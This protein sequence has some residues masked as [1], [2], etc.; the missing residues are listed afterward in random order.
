MSK[1]SIPGGGGSYV[2]LNYKGMGDLLK[3]TEIQSMLRERMAMVQGAVPGSELE[4]KVGRSRARAKVIFG[5]DYEE[6]DTGALSRALDMS[7][8]RR[9]TNI[10]STDTRKHS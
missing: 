3:S 6:A 2:S 8:G 1:S 10:K 5:S 4:V 7:G 9:G